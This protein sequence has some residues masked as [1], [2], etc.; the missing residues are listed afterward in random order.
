ME[1]KGRQFETG[2]FVSID[3]SGI[4]TDLVLHDEWLRKRGVTEN[5]LFSETVG[6]IDERLSYP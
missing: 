3:R 2:Q 4:Q 5:D 1:L 6:R